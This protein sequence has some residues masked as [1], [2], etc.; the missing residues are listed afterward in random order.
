MWPVIEYKIKPSTS[1]C[2]VTLFPRTVFKLILGGPAMSLP[3]IKWQRAVENPAEAAVFC[4]KFIANSTQSCRQACRATAVQNEVH[5]SWCTQRNGKATCY[6]H[7]R[8]EM[9]E[10]WLSLEN[11]S[12]GREGA[13]TRCLK[14]LMDLTWLLPSGMIFT[15]LKVY[16]FET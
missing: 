7:H 2:F 16:G 8:K 14:S 12:M 5:S 6:R 15:L 3:G 13:G 11:W 1:S 4:N 9:Y 10:F